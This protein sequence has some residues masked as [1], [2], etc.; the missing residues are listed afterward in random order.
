MD[1][2][3]KIGSKSKNGSKSKIEPKSKNVPKSENMAQVNTPSSVQICHREKKIKHYLY[4]KN[5][6]RTANEAP[7]IFS[8]VM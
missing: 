3:P 6:I 4:S 1:Q 5:Q 7:M 8:K 2:N